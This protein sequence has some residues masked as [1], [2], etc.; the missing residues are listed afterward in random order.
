MLHAQEVLASLRDEVDMR[1]SGVVRSS[2]QGED[3]AE[4]FGTPDPIPSIGADRCW[5]EMGWPN[6]LEES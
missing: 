6:Q 2:V 5:P 4:L 3:V 1:L